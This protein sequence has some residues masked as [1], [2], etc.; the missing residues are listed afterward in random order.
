MLPA[1]CRRIFDSVSQLFCK[2]FLIP[3]RRFAAASFA[4]DRQC[5][6]QRSKDVGVINNQTALLARIDTV[7]A[8]DGLHERV[9][10]H[11]LVEIDR[12]AA[13]RVK[14]GEPH[15]ADEYQAQ[16]VRRVFELLI[17]RLVV[18]ALSMRHYVD[19]PLLHLFDLVLSRRNHYRHVGG[20]EHV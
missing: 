13:R 6:F 15:G 9:I 18:H 1:K 8:R 3:H 16:R 10:A 20:L 17:E 19:A 11:R 12:R 5:F 14:A 4:V 7:G 2:L